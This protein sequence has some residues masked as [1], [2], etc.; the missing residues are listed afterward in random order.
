MNH[1]RLLSALLAG[2]LAPAALAQAKPEKQEQASS[3][4]IRVISSEALFDEDVVSSDGREIGEVEYVLIDTNNGEIQ[5]VVIENELANDQLVAVPWA[6]I[7][8]EK[9]KGEVTLKATVDQVNK[10]PATSEA[11]IDRMVQPTVLTEI[12]RYW[13]PIQE[14]GAAQQEQSGLPPEQQQ[15]E[16]EEQ[17]R[18]EQQKQEEQ[19]QTGQEP[20]IEGEEPMIEG[21]PPEGQAPVIEEQAQTGTQTETEQQAMAE[22]QGTQQYVLL[23]RTSYRLL[24]PSVQK[25]SEIE[26]MHVQGSGGE[27]LGRIEEV[28]VDLDRGRIAYLLVSR[29]GFLGLGSSYVPVPFRAIDFTGPDAAKLNVAAREFAQMKAY[30]GDAVPSFVNAQEL[31][32]A[33]KQ[34]QVAP[35][36]TAQEEVARGE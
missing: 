1:A 13:I 9:T 8:A 22:P 5:H 3:Q 24:Q 34:F 19:A 11:E 30:E 15:A 18:L 14:Q 32:Q 26:G 4:K 33:F 25:A 16:Q 20:V 35:Y 27:D 7:D 31:A 29:G 12:E 2:A 10:A 23:G 28:V 21:E 6:S 17:A 36:W